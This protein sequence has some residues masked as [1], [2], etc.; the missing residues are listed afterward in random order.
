M[1]PGSG[2]W[3]AARRSWLRRALLLVYVAFYA[4]L[5][6]KPYCTK[7]S[8]LPKGRLFP[9]L[10]GHSCSL[11]VWCVCLGMTPEE[12]AMLE[13]VK[14]DVTEQVRKTILSFLNE[15]IPAMKIPEMEQKSEVK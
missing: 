1:S 4:A 7:M 6:I 2:Q 11:C 14:D 5:F 8:T 10:G 13:T 12:A 3:A 15:T 9:S